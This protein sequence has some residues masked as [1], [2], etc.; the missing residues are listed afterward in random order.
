MDG[1]RARGLGVL[2]EIEVKGAEQVRRKCPGSVSIFLRAP[3]WEVCER[4]LRQRHTE[5]EAAVARRLEAA[6]AE[7]A[8]QGEFDHVVINDDLDAAVARV[9]GLIAPHFREGGATCSTS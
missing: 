6:R 8:R 7:L 1:Y 9:R 3:S 4:R 5:G 2:L